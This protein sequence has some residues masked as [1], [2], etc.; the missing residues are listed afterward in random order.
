MRRS[1]R[2]LFLSLIVANAASGCDGH[3]GEADAPMAAFAL[4][5]ADRADV[6]QLQRSALSSDAALEWATELSK[7]AGARPPHSAAFRAAVEIAKRRMADAGLSRIRTQEVSVA[8]WNRGRI[9]ARL[10]DGTQLRAVALGGSPSTPTGGVSAGVVEV[11]SL[12]TLSA[13]P[14]SAVEGRVVFLNARMTRTRDTS[15]YGAVSG[16]RWSG[17]AAAGSKGAIAFLMRSA[18]TDEEHA[19]TG[20]TSPSASIASAALSNASADELHE[21]LVAAPHSRVFLEV[22]AS[23]GPAGVSWN[24][25]GEIPGSERPNEIMLLGAHLD[26]WDVGQGAVDDGA[27]YGIVLAAAR[28]ITSLGRA[29]K[30]TIRVVLFTNEE[31]G[32]RGAS[33]YRSSLSSSEQ[34]S[35][36]GAIEADLGTGAPYAFRFD[37]PPGVRP[38][39]R[40]IGALLEPLGIAPDGAPAH[41]GADV[42]G[43]AAP[44]FDVAQDATNYFDFHH[45]DG[46]TFAALDADG[47]RQG[48][49]AYATVAWVVS[50]GIATP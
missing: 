31:A 17:P 26:S 41:P 23:R 5:P 39:A 12:A 33:A 37:V 13:L 45:C 47:L 29:P 43:L 34:R 24:V 4:A 11:G 46:D 1:G 38:Q 2:T 36:V 22:G 28:A 6:E 21:R 9:S 3:A 16:A 25:I 44:Q 48:A 32:G 7:E 8:T 10:D 19:H 30:R 18:G 40:A 35:H 27:G 20:A 14:R 15:G 50:E 49:A 42:S